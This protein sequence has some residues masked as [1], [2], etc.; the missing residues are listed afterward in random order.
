MCSLL[1]SFCRLLL[2]LDDSPPSSPTPS[3]LSGV[4]AGSLMSMRQGS[5]MSPP[6]HGLTMASP[7]ASQNMAVWKSFRPMTGG[8]LVIRQGSRGQLEWRR[9]HHRSSPAGLTSA[10][11]NM[12]RLLLKEMPLILRD[13]EEQADKPTSSARDYS[14]HS[15]WA[16]GRGDADSTP[17]CGCSGLR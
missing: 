2:E 12:I 3:A 6:P 10:I 14:R 9:R 13:G 1:S 7:W 8:G 5:M 4:R 15:L 17:R 16:R 11:G